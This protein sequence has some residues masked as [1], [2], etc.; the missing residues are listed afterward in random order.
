MEQQ[1]E[2]HIWELLLSGDNSNIML[3][4]NLMKLNNMSVHRTR[5]RQLLLNPFVSIE[6]DTVKV[7]LILLFNKLV[8]GINYNGIMLCGADWKYLAN[9]LRQV[10]LAPTDYMYIKSVLIY[11]EKLIYN[12]TE[13][14]E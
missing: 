9:L 10:Q 7:G 1:Q 13:I 12:D 4:I 5:V 2:Q 8:A 11:K 6:N 14:Y 3:A